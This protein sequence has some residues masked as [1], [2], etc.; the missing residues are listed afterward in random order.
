MHIGIDQPGA[1]FIEFQNRQVPDGLSLEIDRANQRGYDTAQDIASAA[2]ADRL[3]TVVRQNI[4][5]H[6]GGGR[7][8]VGT[9]DADD[10]LGHV[11]PRQKI[12]TDLKS[13]YA[14]VMR[15]GA[16]YEGEPFGKELGPV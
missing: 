12:R 14:G 7:L 1:A 6:I 9:G 10:R 3:K 4:D 15:A 5:H 13:Q 11:H 16:A 2:V 8:S